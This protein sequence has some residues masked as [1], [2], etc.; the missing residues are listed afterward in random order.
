MVYSTGAEIRWYVPQGLKLEDYSRSYV[1]HRNEIPI[2]KS[3]CHNVVQTKHS[4]LD[5]I[6]G[7]E[8]A[9]KDFPAKRRRADKHRS[10]YYTLPCPIILE[11]VEELEVEEEEVMEEACV[12][13]DSFSCN[14]IS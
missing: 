8:G 4:R 11:L 6:T 14:W 9:S 10:L 12:P 5:Q 2:K 7:A 13:K 3:I 1:K